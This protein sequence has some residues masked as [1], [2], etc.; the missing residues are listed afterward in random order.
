MM[1]R[2]HDTSPSALVAGVPV[3]PRRRPE[4][5]AHKRPN[6]VNYA[7]D[8]QRRKLRWEAYGTGSGTLR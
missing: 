3:D 4:S 5:S 6:G 8:V 7:W 2:D 1:V